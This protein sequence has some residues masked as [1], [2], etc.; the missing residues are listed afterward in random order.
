MSE[1][2]IVAIKV[3]ALVIF[4]VAA[5]L[6]IKPE[7]PSVKEMP[8]IGYYIIGA[9]ALA[10]AIEIGLRLVTHRVISKQITPIVYFEEEAKH[11]IKNLTGKDQ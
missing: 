1:N 9:F 8:L 4:T 5:L 11:L 3:S 7:L 10:L 6:F 2:I